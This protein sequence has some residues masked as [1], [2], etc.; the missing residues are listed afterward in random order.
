MNDQ[1]AYEALGLRP[2]GSTY[3]VEV[4]E[5]QSED[6]ARGLA[7]HYADLWRHT[8]AL[9]RVPFVNTGSDPWPAEQM[10]FIC[11]TEPTRPPA[12]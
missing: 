9:Y 5:C 6:E 3:T 11:R 8:V 10:H 4:L 7:Q 12:P 2:D 1:Q